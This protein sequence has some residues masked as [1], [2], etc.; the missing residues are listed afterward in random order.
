[1]T[2]RHVNKAFETVTNSLDKKDDGKDVSSYS[3]FV[4]RNR[5]ESS[6]DRDNVK[7]NSTETNTDQTKESVEKNKNNNGKKEDKLFFCPIHKE[8][9]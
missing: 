9:K 2:I 1:M 5:H 7:H 8:E 3:N 4:R 6:K